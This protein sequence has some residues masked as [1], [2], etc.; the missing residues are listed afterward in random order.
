MLSCSMTESFDP[1][2]NPCITAPLL[3]SGVGISGKVI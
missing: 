1:T 2:H 3:R